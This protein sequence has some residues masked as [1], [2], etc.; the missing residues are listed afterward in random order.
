MDLALNNQQML[1]CHKTQ[2]IN[3]PTPLICAVKS[4]HSHKMEQKIPCVLLCELI[5]NNL[6]QLFSTVGLWNVNEN[7][8]NLLMKTDL[9]IYIKIG[10]FLLLSFSESY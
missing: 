3:Q 7:F 10:L 5:F 4:M 2:P 9:L 8:T 6:S 1:I